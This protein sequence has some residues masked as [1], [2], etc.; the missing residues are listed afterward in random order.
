[1]LLGRTFGPLC[2]FHRFGTLR[3]IHTAIA[4]STQVTFFRLSRKSV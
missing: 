4:K 3:R 1:M 2:E